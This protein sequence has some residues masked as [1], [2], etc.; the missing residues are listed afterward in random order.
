MELQNHYSVVTI[1]TPEDKAMSWHKVNEIAASSKQARIH[2]R[3]QYHSGA[4]NYSTHLL[5]N[6]KEC[7]LWCSLIALLDTQ[8]I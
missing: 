2:G 7:L 6:M 4:I 1:H 5:L 8:K 3:T